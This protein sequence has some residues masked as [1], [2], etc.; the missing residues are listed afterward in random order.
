MSAQVNSTYSSIDNATMW[1][2]MASTVA[3]PR[4]SWQNVT[5]LALALGPNALVVTSSPQR[6]EAARRTKATIP[7]PLISIQFMPRLLS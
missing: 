5:A 4:A 6:V 2:P 1:T 7:D 3:M